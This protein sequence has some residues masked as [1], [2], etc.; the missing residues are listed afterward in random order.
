M[1]TLWKSVI[2]LSG[3]PRLLNSLLPTAIFLAGLGALYV[4]A[5]IGWQNLF[6]WW[7]ALA[8]STQLVLAAASLL[9]VVATAA[10]FDAFTP[11]F[12]RWA[13][14]YWSDNRLLRWLY[15]WRRK[16]HHR[17]VE[18]SQRKFGELR[19]KQDKGMLSHQEKRHVQQLDELLH[20]YPP[21]P[22]RAMPTFLGNIIHA[23]EDH[24]R[25]RYGLD[26]VVV[27]ARLYSSLNS[28]IQ[29]AV[30]TSQANLSLAVR[31]IAQAAFFAVIG[32]LFEF[33]S[34][35]WPIGL[36]V[37][38]ASWAVAYLAYQAAIQATKSYGELIRA[39]FD[40]YRFDLYQSLHLPLPAQSGDEELENGDVLT[41]FLWRGD[42][43]VQYKHT[44]K[45]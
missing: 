16:H 11:T 13:E 3:K 19:D 2:E 40:L 30:E 38:I 24:A 42:V 41:R 8:T 34:G 21:D 17:V 35:K 43:N 31:L 33:A 20:Y 4:H 5:Q 45:N 15:E 29:D 22:Q 14:G 26:P 18:E 1:E 25:V 44:G 7:Q 39:A 32:A 9:L 12:L 37:L 10:P 27:W 23:A 6:Q 28:T 36:L